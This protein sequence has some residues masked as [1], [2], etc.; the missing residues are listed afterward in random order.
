MRKWLKS[1]DW[2]K[3]NCTIIGVVVVGILVYI[4]YNSVAENSRWEKQCDN[5]GGFVI[6]TRYEGRTCVDAER[7]IILP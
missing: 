2:F 3:I 6:D 1:L 5:M 7:K 4:I